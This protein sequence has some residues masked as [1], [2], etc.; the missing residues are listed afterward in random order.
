M[1]DRKSNRTEAEIEQAALL[2]VS[3]WLGL[4]GYKT[5]FD[6]MPPGSRELQAHGLG[7]N[8]LMRVVPAVH[9]EQPGSMTREEEQA[10]KAQAAQL[11]CVAFEARVLLNASLGLEGGIRLR[12]L[13][14]TS[15][16]G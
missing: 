11:G 7:M 5:D 4:Q 12:I 9:P 15:P 13:S 10:L 3:R 14:K 8:L 6:A 16:S 1:R 2:I